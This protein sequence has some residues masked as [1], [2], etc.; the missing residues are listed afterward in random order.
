MNI[1]DAAQ[2][3]LN[4]FL[5]AFRRLEL[6]PFMALFCEDAS[7]FYP[8]EEWPRKVIGRAQIESNFKE[9]FDSNRKG[10]GPNYLDLTPVDIDI[11]EVGS[12]A[13]VTFHLKK[14]RG[15]GRRTLFLVKRDEG[16]RIL[17]LH[18]SN[19]VSN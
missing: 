14:A 19:T 3:T 4:E 16:L 15:L 8:L 2:H 13:L 7:A 12:N 1:S 17:H 11:V 9:Y 10:P 6:E 18:A 5:G